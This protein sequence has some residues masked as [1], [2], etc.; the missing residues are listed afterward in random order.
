MDGKGLRILSEDLT[1]LPFLR[2]KVYHGGNE[3]INTFTLYKIHH[4]KTV[5]R[6]FDDSL[7]NSVANTAPPAAGVAILYLIYDE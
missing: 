7:V 1:T 5:Y 6:L 2:K 3:Q 4:T